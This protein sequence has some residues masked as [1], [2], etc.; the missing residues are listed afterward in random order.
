MWRVNQ[1]ITKETL[2]LRITTEI[3]SDLAFL[4]FCQYTMSKKNGDKNAENHSRDFMINVWSKILHL[5][6]ASV[7]NISQIN[8]LHAVCG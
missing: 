3:M 2:N 8:N 7:F 5:I 4:E 6:N 1:D